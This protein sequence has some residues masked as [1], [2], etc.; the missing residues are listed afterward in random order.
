[1]T[2][3][4]RAATGS[5]VALLSLTTLDPQP[6]SIGIR[7]TRRVHCIDSSVLDDPKYVELEFSVIPTAAIYQ[8]ILGIFG[9]T[10]ATTAAVTVYVRDETYTWVRKNGIAVRPEPG[11]D[12]NWSY[13]PRNVVILIKELTAV[14]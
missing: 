6:K 11:A 3:N 10:S 1:M 14:S 12:I 2:D 8:T 7:P 5:N 9:L 4:Y 13:F